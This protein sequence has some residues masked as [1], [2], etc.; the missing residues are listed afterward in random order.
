MNIES[1]S[2]VVQ[3][4][5]MCD[6][7]K[8]V[9]AS[10]IALGLVIGVGAVKRE[11]AEAHGGSHDDLMLVEDSAGLK[12]VIVHLGSWSCNGVSTYVESWRC[13]GV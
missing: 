8:E 4:R 1:G 13:D 10:G 9:D 6:G 5:V 11:L 12:L 7:W 3:T 2:S